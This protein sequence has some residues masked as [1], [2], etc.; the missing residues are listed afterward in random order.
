M[1]EHLPHVNAAL[2][3]VATVLLVWGGWLIRRRRED[4]HRRVMLACF[5]VSCLFL[6]SYLTYHA[7][8]G[9]QVFPGTGGVRVLYLAIL[10]SHIVLAASVPILAILAI[11]FGLKDR[12]AAHVRIVRWAYPIWLYVS[13][14]GVVVYIMLY[15]LYAVPAAA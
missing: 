7:L 4:S 15:H 2:N 3:L 12:R 9:H 13:I 11:Y 5:G 14:T 6:V 1:V 10:L 8:A